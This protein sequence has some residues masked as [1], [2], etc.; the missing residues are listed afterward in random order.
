MLRRE[1]RRRLELWRTTIRVW[2]TGRRLSRPDQVVQAEADLRAELGSDLLLV[3][4]EFLGAAL[5]EPGL[6][7]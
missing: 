4:L 5:A 2:T 3:V 1:V 7:S 6:A